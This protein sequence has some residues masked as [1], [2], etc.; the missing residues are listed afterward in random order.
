MVPN[1]SHWKILYW[2]D[3]KNAKTEEDPQNIKIVD[4]FVS[5]NGYTLLINGNM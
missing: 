1:F 5:Y 3:K 2:L 4:S